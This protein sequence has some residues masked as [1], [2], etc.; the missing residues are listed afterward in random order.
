MTGP[1]VV[2]SLRVPEESVASWGVKVRGTVMVPFLAIGAGT[3]GV[4]TPAAKPDPVTVMPVT[5]RS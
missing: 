4:A 5:V 3:G 1:E 2:S